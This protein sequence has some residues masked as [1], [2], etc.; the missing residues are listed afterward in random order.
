MR[1]RVVLN[2]L[3]ADYFRDVMDVI[4]KICFDDN[5][6]KEHII[7]YEITIFQKHLCILNSFS[8]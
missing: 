8:L 5:L 6:L 2:L 1:Y 3:R 7:F 4:E